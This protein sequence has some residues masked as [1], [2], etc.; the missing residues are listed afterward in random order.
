MK[1]I[2]YINDNL[3]VTTA[4]GLKRTKVF[5]NHYGKEVLLAN[6]K[7]I[8]DFFWIKTVNDENYIL[9]YSRGDMSNQI[10]LCIEAAYNIKNKS[11]VDL[12]NNKTR[13]LLEYMLISKRGFDLA[14]VLEYI[15][16]YPLQ[17]VDEEEDI[18]LVERYLTCGN[19]EISKSQIIKYI[20]E[21]YPE[22]EKH[23]N[24]TGTLSVIQYRDIIDSLGTDTLWFHEI[25][26]IVDLSPIEKKRLRAIEGLA[27][28][29]EDIEKELSISKRTS[30]KVRTKKK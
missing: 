16:N 28:V 1:E 2:K 26:Q 14:T 25:P 4:Y 13:V 8:A 5:V 7:K 12:S 17:I 18:D 27:D 21:N 11:I 3:F 20:L 23:M 19:K 22:L 24:Y 29:T 30:F 9:V 10:P 15:N 6:V